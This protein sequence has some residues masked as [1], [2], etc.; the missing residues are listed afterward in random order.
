MTLFIRATFLNTWRIQLK[1]SGN[2]LHGQ[3]R[4]GSLLLTPR[5]EVW[6]GDARTPAAFISVGAASTQCYLQISLSE[7]ISKTFLIMC[8]RLTLPIS[9]ASGTETRVSPGTRQEQAYSSS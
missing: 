4:E 9:L 6:T 1:F 5:M 7:R 2:S 3:K 8:R